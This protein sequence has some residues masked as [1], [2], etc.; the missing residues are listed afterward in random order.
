MYEGEEF[1]VTVYARSDQVPGATQDRYQIEYWLLQLDWSPAAAL[2]VTSADLLAAARNPATGKSAWKSVLPG[3]GTPNPLTASGSLVVQGLTIA[4]D[5]APTDTWGSPTFLIK[6]RMRANR[7]FGGSAVAVSITQPGDPMTSANANPIGIG[8]AGV[9]FDARDGAAATGAT[10]N[11]VPATPVALFAVPCG[12]R[13]AMANYAAATGARCRAPCTRRSPTTSRPK[14]TRA[15]PPT[16][17]APPRRAP[18]QRPSPTTIG[19]LA[20]CE[21]RPSASTAAQGGAAAVTVSYGGLSSAMS[22]SVAVPT[23]LELRADDVE[24]TAIGELCGGAT[25]YQSTRLRLLADGLDISHLEGVEFVSS[26]SSV[27]AID[28]VDAS[29]ARHVARGEAAGS[30]DVRLRANAGVTATITVS[31]T[32][33]PLETLSA[34]A[35]TG[36]SVGGGLGSAL[37]LPFTTATPAAVQI[38]KQEGDIGWVY[39]TMRYENG[40]EHIVAAADLNLTAIDPGGGNSPPVTATQLTPRWEIEVAKDAMNSCNADILLA[41]TTV[42]GKPFAPYWVPSSS[43]SPSPSPPPSASQGRTFPPSATSPPTPH[44]PTPTPPDRR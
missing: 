29:T 14:R 21:F 11:V 9:V 39:A 15:P 2:S 18:F 41:T 4:D 42:C 6:L 28:T 23:T 30:A 32:I 13:V 44:S 20:G 8:G 3:A 12:G 36:A 31:D 27:V 34:V 22:L 17:S 10:V 37:A 35:I 25:T 33:V 40:D 24:L 38:F 19:S 1:D 16:A 43:I 7:G 26:S 5:A